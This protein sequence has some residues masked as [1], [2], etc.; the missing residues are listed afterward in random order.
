MANKDIYNGL[1][2]V[3]IEQVKPLEAENS[4]VRKMVEVLDRQGQIEPLQVKVLAENS[5]TT[6]EQDAWGDEIIYAAKRLGWKTLLIA[7]QHK[8]EF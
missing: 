4:S 7:P 5:Y 6:F 1:Q 2:V 8:Y 3:P